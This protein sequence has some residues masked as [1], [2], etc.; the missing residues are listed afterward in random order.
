M[1]AWSV[2]FRP[3]SSRRP[4]SIPYQGTDQQT[5]WKPG[6]EAPAPVGTRIAP[7]RLPTRLWAWH[8]PLP[9]APPAPQRI[10]PCAKLFVVDGD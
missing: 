2:D 6:A 10:D 9:L 4:S 1:I 8:V 7:R 5:V 3:G